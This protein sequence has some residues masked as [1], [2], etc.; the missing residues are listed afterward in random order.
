MER[1]VY[2]AESQVALTTQQCLLLALLGHIP[3]CKFGAGTGP[4][5]NGQEA[6]ILLKN[7]A[8]ESEGKR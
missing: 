7:S 4:R 1:V 5:P 2:I 6:R 8:V 3:N